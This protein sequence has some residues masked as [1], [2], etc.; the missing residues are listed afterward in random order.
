MH[1]QTPSPHSYKV[2]TDTA[3]CVCIASLIWA[4]MF[5]EQILA[6]YSMSVKLFYFYWYPVY[7]N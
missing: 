6:T 7:Q 4:F 3:M 2:D 1:T 5:T